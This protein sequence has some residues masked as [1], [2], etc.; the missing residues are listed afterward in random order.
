MR[1]LN[2]KP[3]KSAKPAATVAKPVNTAPLGTAAAAQAPRS[4]VVSTKPSK[5]ADTTPAVAKPVAGIARTIRTIAA[6]ATN[7][8]GLSDRDESY[9]KFYAGLIK[10]HGGAVTVLQIHEAGKAHGNR[11]PHYAGSSKP[12]DAGAINRLVAANLIAETGG[13]LKL[14]RDGATHK[15]S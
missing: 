15:I 11:N 13:V 5:P 2:V 6:R 7:F 4:N 12:H 10:Q 14:G 9:F 1:K 3:A 8:G